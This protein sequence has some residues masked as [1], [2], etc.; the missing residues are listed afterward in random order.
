MLLKEM[1]HDIKLG[2][3]LLAIALT[4]LFADTMPHPRLSAGLL[5]SS[6]VQAQKAF[7][8][9]PA[10]ARLLLANAQRSQ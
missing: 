1:L 10:P 8:E 7:G 9:L 6:V 2:R 4:V 5:E 3:L